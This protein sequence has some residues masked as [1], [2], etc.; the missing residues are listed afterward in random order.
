[1]RGFSAVIATGNRSEMLTRTI[2]SIAKQ[3]CQPLEI[4]I[5]DSSSDHDTFSVCRSFKNLNANIK[6]V[7]A[8]KK[9]SASQRNQG[10]SLADH[11][12]I[13]FCDDDIVFQP[14]CLEKL[15]EAIN[16]S[17]DVGGC[18][19]LI[20]NQKF[21]EPGTTSRI[22]YQLMSGGKK[23]NAGECFGP[24]INLL[25]DDNPNLPA[26]VEVDWLN[27]TCTL[28]RREALPEPP[29]DDHFSG[30]S[31][32]EDVAL[33]LRVRKSW[34][35]LN[36]REAIIFHDSQTGGEKS[37]IRAMAHMDLVNRYY[38][39]KNVLGQA[40]LK[41]LFKLAAHQLFMA[42]ASGNVAKTQCW[43]GKYSG[44]KAIIDLK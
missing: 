29:F 22:F 28:Y 42:I 16:L 8:N 40:V 23:V 26:H 9:G 35:L 5:V 3:S 20:S 13:L 39:M 6:Y 18:N 33:S 25:P 38:I 21:H 36:V 14:N 34:K 27:T 32:M 43:K 44:I 1:M 12:F 4:I 19:A 31:L 10:V 7:Q 30:Y 11:P 37:D 41:N 24:V 17:P 2:E 15:W